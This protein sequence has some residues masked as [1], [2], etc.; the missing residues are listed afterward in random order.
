MFSILSN[1]VAIIVFLGRYRKRWL[2]LPSLILGVILFW[3][4][5]TWNRVPSF[6]D[7]IDILPLRLNDSCSIDVRVNH[8]YYTF[9]NFSDNFWGFWTD[10]G[11]SSGG[12]TFNLHQ[13]PGAAVKPPLVAVN[14]T[15]ETR[16]FVNNRT[17]DSIGNIFEF[18]VRKELFG[19]MDLRNAR[20]RLRVSHDPKGFSISKRNPKYVNN[21][22]IDSVRILAGVNRFSP[23]PLPTGYHAEMYYTPVRLLRMEDIS[24]FNYRLTLNDKTHSLSRLELGFGGPVDIKGLWPEPDII[25]P[26]RIIYRS[27]DKISQIHEAGGVKMFCQSL[28]SATVQNV[29][30]F[31]LTTIVSVCFAYTLR[32]IC[33]FI[34]FILRFMKKKCLSNS[35][36]VEKR[37]ES[38][39]TDSIKQK[40]QAALKKITNILTQKK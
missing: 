1:I 12:V 21:V 38:R 28:E 29:R 25:E 4:F 24:Q 31:V 37:P 7:R 36:T 11:T 40:F 3:V 32:E 5:L 6:S 13:H 2:W 8:P 20:N 30:L 23:A 27:P 14:I 15:D 22:C 10:Y 39:R 16:K 17:L 18:R 34:I 35:G 26:S 19:S 33:V 9:N